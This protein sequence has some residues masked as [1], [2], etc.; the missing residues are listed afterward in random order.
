VSLFSAPTV[1]APEP[2]LFLMV[3]DV[4]TCLGRVAPAR[5]ESRRNGIVRLR[6]AGR[7]VLLLGEDEVTERQRLAVVS[8]DHDARDR[9]RQGRSA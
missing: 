3:W 6:V 5:V 4:A 9:A 1:E 7:D 2:E 8:Q